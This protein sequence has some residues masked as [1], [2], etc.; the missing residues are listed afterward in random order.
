MQLLRVPHSI[1]I[2]THNFQYLRIIQTSRG[3]TLESVTRSL[4]FALETGN[5]G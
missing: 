4:P 3:L 2:E 1:A 5:A